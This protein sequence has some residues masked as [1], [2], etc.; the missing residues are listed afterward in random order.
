MVG[1]CAMTMGAPSNGDSAIATERGI[2]ASS[3]LSPKCLRAC[4][5][6][7]SHSLLLAW[8]IVRRIPKSLSSGFTDFWT[9]LMAVISCPMPSRA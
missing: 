6:T 9:S 5:V 3:T 4:S 7:V 2:C 1:F 8:T